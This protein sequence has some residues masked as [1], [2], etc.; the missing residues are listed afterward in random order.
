MLAYVRSRLACWRSLQG[1]VLV[2]ILSASLTV[3]VGVTLVS[4]LLYENILARQV[5]QTSETLARQSFNAMLQVMR[6]GWSRDEM[7]AFID[8]TKRAH[9]GAGYRFTFYRGE[10]VSERYGVIDQPPLDIV[11]RSALETGNERVWRENGTVRRVMPLLARPECLACH[12]NAA[13]GDV[14]GVIDIQRDMAPISREMRFNYLALFIVAALLILLLALGMSKL[15]AERIQVTLDQFR[16]RLAAVNSVEDFRKLDVSDT[17]VRFQELNI[18]MQ[19]VN[20]LVDRLRN[21]AVDKD[22]LEF[23]IRLLSKFIITSEVVRDW[24]EFIK[25]LLADINTIIQAHTLVTIFQ[26]EDEGYE[27]EVFWYRKVAPETRETFEALLSQLLERRHEDPPAGSILKVLHHTVMTDGEGELAARLTPE[28]I[29]LQTKSLL[30]EAPKIGGIVGI[31][32]QSD[33]AQDPIRHIVIDGILSTLLNLVGSVKAIYKYTK[34]LEY[35]ATRDPLT[36]LYNQRIFKDML[37]YEVG[38]ATRHQDHF[39]LLM[40]DLDN[41]KTVNDR[42]G[43]AFGDQFLHAVADTLAHSVRPG[44]F[45]ARYGGDEFTVILPETEEQQ[46]YSVALRIA[47]KLAGQV[48]TAP[49]GSVVRATT[50]IGIASYPNHAENPHDLFLMADNMMY[51]AKRQGKNCVALP[52]REEVAEVFRKVGEKNQ[53]V[54]SALEE[55]RI[56]PYFQPIA[57]VASGE[58]HIHELLMRIQ[59]DDRLV[60]A[61]EFID[62][63]ESIGVI[64]KMDYQL[65]EK[66][67]AQVREQHYEGMLFINLSPKSLIVGEFIGHIHQL[68]IDYDILPERI[69]F[70]LTERETVSNLKLLEKFV[71]DLKLEGFNFAIDD[72]G[73][74]YSSFRYLKQFP[75]DVIKI[76]GEFIRNML[77]DE[78][79][80]AFV[81]SIVTLAQSLGVSTVAEFI[82]DEAV[83]EAVRAL[84]IDFGQGYH[85]GRPGP[86]FVGRR[87]AERLPSDS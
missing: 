67:F 66:A 45:L 48:L 13:T 64:H 33:L 81:K 55:Q 39:S 31:G 11:I 69:V 12:Q 70:E 37:A 19:Q 87:Q 3:F 58:V 53:M 82:E 17:Q 20:A 29:R 2:A 1:F 34:D 49:D 86:R 57:N 65:V 43:H 36:S 21:V 5:E 52:E 6:Q 16:D 83:L 18:A 85:L 41:F 56:V 30:L 74:G 47:D 28:D 7:E 78:T 76:E 42:H 59:L 62:L 50:S 38:R 71:H 68:A 51:K 73:S 10:R 77:D 27:L 72:F 26:V 79:Y 63:A 60:P 22:I 40:L 8:E 14:L 9:A 23:E 32:V 75:I 84:G 46:A 24:R 35:Y 15:F 54:L 4:S 61:G 25:E 80:M 44:D